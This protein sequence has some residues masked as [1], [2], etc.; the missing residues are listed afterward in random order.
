MHNLKVFYMY[1]LVQSLIDASQKLLTNLNFIWLFHLSY[2]SQLILISWEN[3]FEYNDKA[4]NYKGNGV[5]AF[6]KN[7]N[8][9][10]S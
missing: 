4:L 6:G 5:T 1:T 10:K 3:G 2:D 7:I 9:S 8:T